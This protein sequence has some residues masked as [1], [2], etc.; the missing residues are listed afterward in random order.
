M[1][2]ARTWSQETPSQETRSQETPSQETRSQ[3]TRSQA[4]SDAGA[5]RLGWGHRLTAW[6]TAMVFLVLTAPT[7]TAQ[8]K[9]KQEEDP[10]LKPRAVTMKTKDG[11]NLRAAYFPSDKG[12]EAITI[13]LVH[14]WQGQVGPYIRLANAFKQAGFAVLMP[15]YRGHGGSREYV[16]SR[17]A[18]QQFNT[19][20]M[21]KKDIENIV[22]FDLEEAKQFLKKENNEGNL[23]MN[24][25]VVVGVREGAVMAAHWTIRDWR[26]PS[27]GSVKQGQDVK[28]LV[29][30]S[31]EKVALG[32]P[33]D[34]TLSDPNLV[35]LPIMLV[36][37][38]QSPEADETMRVFK[39]LEIIKKK[40]TRGEATG[41]EL[42]MAKTSL[43]GHALVNEQA[44]V[45]PGIVKFI[46]E[47][48]K[49]SDNKNPW[50]ER[51]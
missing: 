39:R 14:E 41:L 16:D 31:P 26:F 19:A 51:P 4:L 34:P 11:V 27:L 12:K 43:S 49:V 40:M 18:P 36:A 9:K 21:S 10:K 6:C 50:V 45:V 44:S 23:N 8:T 13:L 35:R 42:N 33:L 1:L 48:V 47:N 22:K 38:D 30:I 25:L 7:I 24:A 32:V 2:T 29:L 5:K 28:A 46:T 37:G 20:R 17:G 15:D 3:E